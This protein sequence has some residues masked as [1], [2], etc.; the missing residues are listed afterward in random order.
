[1]Y[2]NSNT[3]NSIP[4]NFDKKNRKSNNSGQLYGQGTSQP[5]TSISSPNL[6]GNFHPNSYGIPVNPMSQS[7]PE[8]PNQYSNPYNQNPYGQQYYP[9]MNNYAPNP[10]GHFQN[11]QGM[12]NY[13]PNPY[14]QPQPNPYGMNQP[15]YGQNGGYYNQMPS[16][17]PMTN[18]VY[19]GQQINQQNMIFRKLLANYADSV[20]LECD[21]NKSGF[22][23]V[24]E[25]YPAIS[26]VFAMSNHPPPSYQNV[27]MIMKTFDT[28]GNGL[29]DM[30][31]FRNVIY[32]MNGL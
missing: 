16:T 26:K 28:D 22:L 7:F 6:G 31:E 17:P 27:L 2:P 21:D 24:R 30:E 23:D 29:L 5:L 18:Q 11:N 3:N 12:P 4:T 8:I 14:G 15:P 13:P 25:I 1:M 19:S 20:F 10:Y 32:A 9:G